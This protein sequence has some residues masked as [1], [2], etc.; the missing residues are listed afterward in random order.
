MPAN[1]RDDLAQ[2]QEL[3]A[4]KLDQSLLSQTITR[5]LDH[6]WNHSY[7]NWHLYEMP[8]AEPVIHAAGFFGLHFSFP[9]SVTE[10]D[11]SDKCRSEEVG[12]SRSAFAFQ[13]KQSE[14]RR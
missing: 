6:K 5:E 3:E 1:T 9:I 8:V 4:K 11:V 2:N 14:G 7:T 12:G 10:L 13:I